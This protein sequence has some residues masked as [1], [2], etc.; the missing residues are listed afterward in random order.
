MSKR[1]I[2]YVVVIAIAI[3]LV[4]FY[5]LNVYMGSL[6]LS[7]VTGSSSG[8]Q[9]GG[10]GYSYSGQTGGSSSSTS[11]SSTSSGVKEFTIHGYAY[12]YSPSTI[13]V[14]KGDVVKITF[15]SDDIL[16]NLSIEGYNIATNSV[17][18]G[19]STTNMA[20]TFVYYCSI[21]GHKDA[22]MVGTLIVD[23]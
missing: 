15:I 4:V 11:G 14:N 19:Q 20:G 21:P 10:S 23:G 16:H 18:N 5:G 7:S 6:S 13:E 8:G 22:G 1:R 3:L 12:G 17:A 2:L 9:T